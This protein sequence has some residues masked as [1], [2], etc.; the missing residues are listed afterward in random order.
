MVDI[1]R[2]GGHSDRGG[3]DVAGTASHYWIICYIDRGPSGQ[4]RRASDNFSTFVLIRVVRLTIETNAL[5]GT[6]LSEK[7]TQTYI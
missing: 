4:L 2:L 6:C 5:T 1:E 7:P 3:D